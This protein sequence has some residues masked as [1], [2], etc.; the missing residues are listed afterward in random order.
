MDSQQQL[1]AAL[2]MPPEAEY[3][4]VLSLI[5]KCHSEEFVH[6]RLAILMTIFSRFVDSEQM[7]KRLFA[8]LFGDPK[9]EFGRC[10]ETVAPHSTSACSAVPSRGPVLRREDMDDAD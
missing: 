9:F 6:A 4:I 5:E 2:I 7:W 10:I 3:H 8:L 1:S